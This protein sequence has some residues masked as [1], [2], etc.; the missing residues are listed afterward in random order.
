MVASANRVKIVKKRT[1]RFI[2]HQSDKYAC[3]AQS[4]RKPKGIDNVVR[5]RM[6]GTYVMPKIGYRNNHK[7]RHLLPDGFR[8]FTV[9]NLKELE[10]L[11]LHNRTF[12][13]EIAHNVSSRNRKAIV[14]RAAQLNIKVLNANARLRT[15]ASE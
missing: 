15:E 11:L 10:V 9:A 6:H 5:R 8:K 1:K 2:R 3:V 14:E 13:A 12:A 7:T 4:W